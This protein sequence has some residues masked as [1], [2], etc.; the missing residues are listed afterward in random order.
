MSDYRALLERAK[1]Q[2]PE[3]DLQLDGVLRRR[4]RHRRNQRLAAGATVAAILV[5]VATVIGVIAL[6]R[7]E[8]VPVITPS[9]TTAPAPAMHNGPLYGSGFGFV[10]EYDGG[11]GG[12]F[13]VKCGEHCNDIP[14][15]VWSADGS[16]LAF[17]ASAFDNP[18]GDP[19]HGLRIVNPTTGSD[20]LLVPGEFLGPLAWSP[21]GSRIVYIT[22]GRM[23][24][25]G[26]LPWVVTG[27]YGSWELRTVSLDGSTDTSLLRGQAPKPGSLSWSPDGSR[28]A[29][30]AGGKVFVLRP[31][32]SGPS[33]IA[34]GSDAAW[35]PDGRTIAYVSGCEVRLTTPAGRH[36]R[37]LIDL[38]TPA[39]ASD[40]RAETLTWSP[41]GTQFTVM[42][43]R[44]NG[45]H[46]QFVVSADGSRH[47][48]LGGWTRDNIFEGLKWRPVP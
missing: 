34:A 46:G 29:Y 1:Q 21:D 15:F 9:P 25:S 30:A 32:G 8:P 23:T 13:V 41:D 11:A 3:P 37:S 31:G 43:T 45:T 40:C 48:L 28:L 14:D 26:W 33:E 6:Q 24:E 36:D 16:Q 27:E 18:D 2:A 38:G 47:H 5:A 17:S 10:R 22:T 7:T 42:V 44:N 12:A 19:Y 20:R 35:S 4:D 39:H